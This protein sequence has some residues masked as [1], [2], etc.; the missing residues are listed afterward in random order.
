MNVLIEKIKS[1]WKWI[2]GVVFLFIVSVGTIFRV[3]SSKNSFEKKSHDKFVEGQNSAEAI[4]EAGN[5]KI[6][7]AE[8]SHKDLIKKIHDEKNEK[9]NEYSS[10]DQ[11]DLTE[12]LSRT[13]GIKNGDKK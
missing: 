12:D 8:I 9:F 3:K 13:F 5:K 10:K 7:N 2:L 4:I 6:E 11:A 1:Y